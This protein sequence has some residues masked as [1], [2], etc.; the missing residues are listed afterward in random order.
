MAREQLVCILGGIRI[1][2]F[3]LYQLSENQVLVDKDILRGTLAVPSYLR[4]ALRSLSVDEP[5]VQAFYAT[6]KKI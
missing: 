5:S 3:G 1:I 6:H 2:G 4:T